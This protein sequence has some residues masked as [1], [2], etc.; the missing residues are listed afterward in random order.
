MAT[1]GSR[2]D[3]EPFFAFAQKAKRQG[4]DVVLACTSDFEETS[5]NAGI[6]TVCLPGSIHTLIQDSGVSPLKAWRDFGSVV[7]PMMTMT[8]E[9]AADAIIEF[10]PDVVI[11]HPK[12]LS[13]PIAAGKVGAISIITD[14]VPLTS[15]TNEFGAA[16]IGTG[17]FGV[18]NRATYKAIA[19]SGKL[20]DKELNSIAR[21]ISGEVKS[22]D[23]T[24]CLVSPSILPRPHD[25]P[26]TTQL[27]GP[28]V[29]VDD[30]RETDTQV[31][32]F[33][34]SAPTILA[35]FGSMKKGDAAKRTSVVVES[36]RKLGFQALLITGWGG[37]VSCHEEGVMSVSSTN[38][39]TVLPLVSG[40]IHHGGAGTVHAALRAGTPSVIVPFFADQP[41]WAA[42]LR[43]LGLGPRGIKESHLSQTNL[44]K[45]ISSLGSYENKVREV[46][47]K[48][49]NEDGLLRR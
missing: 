44:T 43:S 2:G 7:K 13:A 24:V 12:V 23:Y 28:W 17:N 49:K 29:N 3:F 10:K 11:Y 15:P 22:A 33:V 20:F 8:L 39:N 41:W 25:W 9:A 21:R 6:K 45:A 34:S 35:G 46:A 18:F 38:F 1:L 37:L 36:I 40:A 5:V 48:M 31:I 26:S 47:E 30:S 14:I 4:H 42:R 19:Q 16:G 32:D 27:V